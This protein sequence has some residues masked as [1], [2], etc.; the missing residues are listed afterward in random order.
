M[1]RHEILGYLAQMAMVIPAFLIAVSFHEC[2]HALM[3]WLLG[4]N[5]ARNQGRLTLNPFAHLD[6]L[7]LAFLVIF[8]IGWANPVPFDQ[9]NFKYPRLFS[10]MTALAGPLSNFFL[11]LTAFVVIKYLPAALL[12]RAIYISL[13]QILQAIAWVNIMLGVFNLLPIPPLDGSHLIIVFLVD[14]YPKAVAFLYRY[15]MIFLLFIFLL[16][17]TREWLGVAMAAVEQFL[18]GLVF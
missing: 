2:C 8:G 1:V 7:G 3:A 13:V 18:K 12:A 5:T 6:L 4:D 10:V 14:R 9:R 15:A 16:P 11:A 17:P